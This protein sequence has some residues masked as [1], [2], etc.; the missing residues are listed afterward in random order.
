V[1]VRTPLSWKNFSEIKPYVIL[2]PD[3]PDLGHL[4]L[5][6]HLTLTVDIFIDLSSLTLINESAP[7]W[8]WVIDTLNTC[9]KPS[10][11]QELHIIVHT[12]SPKQ[13]QVY[14]WAALDSVFAMS[15]DDSD[16]WPAL[17]LVDISICAQFDFNRGYL[18]VLFDQFLTGKMVN[19]VR[20]GVTLR[21]R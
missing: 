2:V 1:E 6:K 21:G 13:T 17:E 12:N 8:Q 20:K 10:T 11:I 9:D 18:A 7:R 3:V 19:L 4:P 15:E 5:L 14:D 16:S